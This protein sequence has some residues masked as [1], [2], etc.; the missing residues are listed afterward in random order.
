[1]PASSGAPVIGSTAHGR[2][3][4]VLAREDRGRG[5]TH[6]DRRG[7]RQRV[8]AGVTEDLER[9]VAEDV[10]REAQARAELVVD[11]D[12]RVAEAVE[13]FERIPA[14]ADVGDEVVGDVPGCP[15]RRTRA[16]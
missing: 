12:E 15:G 2:E 13:V 9:G 7:Q 4:V 11:L 5:T 14:Q 10:P 6:G 16:A 3:V 8:A 1:M